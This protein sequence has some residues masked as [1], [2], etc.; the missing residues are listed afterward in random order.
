[1]AQVETEAANSTSSSQEIQETPKIDIEALEEA[2]IIGELRSDFVTSSPDASSA[3][4]NFP[5]SKYRDSVS[6]V[7]GFEKNLHILAKNQYPGR[8]MGVFTS[9]G[10]AQGMNPAVRAI[11]RMGIYLGCKVYFIHE[12]YQ[13]LVD[14]GN[15][16]RQATWASVSGIIDDGGTIIGS[17]R[18]KEFRERPGRL[19]AAKNLIEHGINNIVCIGGDGSLTGANLFRKEWDS[20]LQELV[21]KKEVTQENAST[22]KHLNIVGLVGSIDNDFCGTDMTIG[23][24]SALHRIMEAIDCITTTASSHQR[25]FVLEVMGRHCGYLALVSALG[26]D[27]DWVFIPEAPPGPG[28]EDQLCNKLQNTRE[29]GQRL[30]IIV[31]AEGAIDSNGKQISSEDVRQLISTRLKYDTRITILG[32]VQRGGCPSAFDRLL[33]TR[34]GTEAVLALME[35]TP[36][37]QPVVIAISGNQ[38]VRVPLMHCV[39][40]T[41]AVAEAMSERRFKEAQELRGRSFKGNLE[42]YIRLSKLRPKLFSNK[43]HSFNLAVLNVGAPACGVNAIVRSIVRYGLCEG[44][45]MFAIFDGFEGLI[46]NQIKSLHWMAVNGWSSVGSSLL[47]CQKTSASKVGLE[48]IAEKIREHNFH[49]LLIIGGYEAYLS[50]LEMYEARE[51][52]LQFQIPLICIPATISNNVPGTEFSI[53]ADTALNE[54][55]QICDKIKQSAQGSKRRIFVIETMGGYCGY[56]AT[57]AALASGADQAY[58]YEEPFTIKDLIDD[59]DHLRKKMEGHLKRGLLLRNERA[60]EHYTTEFITKLLQEEGKGV[61]SARSN[62]LG[63]MQQGGLPS[64]FDR[65]FGTKLGCKA[66][67]YAVSLIEKAATED[68]KVICNTAESAVVLG[69]IKRQNEFT[70]VEILKANTDTEHRMPLEQWWLKLRPLLRILAKHESVYIGDFVETG[71]EDVD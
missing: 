28:W 60:N 58:I 62:V 8:S 59:V 44:H 49:A 15:S 56:L 11:V 30:N 32:H 53:G 68:G 2:D 31:L 43:Q 16:I 13:G 23:T 19:R 1:M 52:Y 3:L 41:L 33:A 63:H 39:E 24:D 51:Q 69:L 71:L 34:M 40:K 35:A 45:N 7:E 61:F 5:F 36:T 9:G 26:S 12:G 65:A 27:A 17:A 55:V 37:S 64:P 21:E 29:M 14:G 20:L 46:N 67:T 42:T 48:L 10:D 47:G 6:G 57:M 22:Y 54:I 70:P 18:C 50:V 66:V 4:L 38:T 25:C